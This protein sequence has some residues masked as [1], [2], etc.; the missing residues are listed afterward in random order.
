MN[1]RDW[2]TIYDD[3]TRDFEQEL[4]ADDVEVPIRLETI[5]EHILDRMNTIKYKEEQKD[6]FRNELDLFEV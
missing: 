1:Q 3:D 4:V 5:M 6:H 2:W